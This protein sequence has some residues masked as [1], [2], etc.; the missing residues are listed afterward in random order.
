MKDPER[1]VDRKEEKWTERGS[2]GETTA[3]AKVANTAI[4]SPFPPR[5]LCPLF[6]TLATSTDHHPAAWLKPAGIN[7]RYAADVSGRNKT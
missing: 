5:L 1:K 3:K 4:Q 2:G 6:L 7:A